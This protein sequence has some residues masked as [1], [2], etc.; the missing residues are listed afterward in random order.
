MAADREVEISRTLLDG[1]AFQK[2]LDHARKTDPWLL[3]I[4]RVGVHASPGETG[5]G[6][7]T[8]NLLRSSPVDV[9]LTTRLEYPE[10]DL[11]AE[12]SIRFTPEAEE[13][14]KRIPAMVQG[15]ARTAI[16]R[17]AVEQG[18]SVITS[19]V[20]DRAMERYMPSATARQTARLAEA[21]AMEHARRHQVSVCRKCGLAASEEAP[22]RCSVCGG[23]SFEIVTEEMLAQIAALEGGLAQET[24]YDGRKLSWSQDAKRALWTLKDAYQRRRAKARVEKSARIKKLPVITLEFAQRVIEDETGVPLVLAAAGEAAP[25]EEADELKLRARDGERNPLV[26]ARTWSDAAVER[27]FRVPVGFMRE[28]TQARAEALAAE[29]GAAT[30]GL[31]LVEAAL[32]Q[33]RV[34][35]ERFIAEQQALS[36]EA[37]APRPPAADRPASGKCPWHDA[38]ADIVRRPDAAAAARDG[39]YL[40]EVGLMS[41]LRAKPKE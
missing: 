41:A 3:V 16:F 15:V 6:S 7:N 40:N 23:E 13:R 5:L 12:Q 20:L 22:V 9:L 1:K 37:A 29:Q 32:E 11:K 8:E 26:S 25:A 38:A 10:L 33:G 30:V 39:L 34:A 21:L 24:T 2:V 19:D 4:G 17:L 31:E 35:M 18:H 14:M 36:E 28:R 27:L